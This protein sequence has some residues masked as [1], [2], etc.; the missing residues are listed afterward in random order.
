MRAPRE[1]LVDGSWDA[2]QG[3]T[4]TNP[5]Q[6]SPG[7]LHRFLWN[8]Y[9]GQSERK[10]R[11]RHEHVDAELLET[12]VVGRGCLLGHRRWHTIRSHDDHD[13]RSREIKMASRLIAEPISDAGLGQ[14]VSR[15][16]GLVLELVPE[17]HHVDA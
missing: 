5:A 2:A 9:L 8:L 3:S 4:R 14:Q 17:L 13:S 12:P 10:G 1:G 16:R 7:R 11:D 6:R 15:P